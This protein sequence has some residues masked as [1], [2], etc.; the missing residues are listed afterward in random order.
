MKLYRIV[1]HQRSVYPEDLLLNPKEHPTIK[2]GKAP[3]LQM[4]AM[5]STPNRITGDIVEIY[6]PEEDDEKGQQKCRL[7][8]QVSLAKDS[9]SRDY[10]SVESSIALTF[11]LKNYG[12]VRMRVIEDPSTVALDSVEITFKDQYM[13]R[14]EMWRLKQFLT[15][16][17]VYI[18]KKI[19]YCESIRC[20]G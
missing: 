7:L 17:C 20:Q 19:E 6:H 15:N 14:S 18:N 10:I 3:H 12:D 5:F 4:I 1:H 8:L 13:G 16:T 11:N 9:Q 2:K